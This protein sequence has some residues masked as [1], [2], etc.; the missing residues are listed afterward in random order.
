MWAS[1]VQHDAQVAQALLI[2]GDG[3]EWIWN[4]NQM[5]PEK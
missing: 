2:L 1:S 3:A 4:L 5:A